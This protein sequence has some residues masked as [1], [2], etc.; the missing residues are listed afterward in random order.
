MSF[1]RFVLDDGWF[2]GR[3]DDRAGLGD[4]TVDADVWPDGLHPLVDAV[5]VHGMQ[6]GLWIEPETV[7]LAREHPDWLLREPG[8]LSWR[9]EFALDRG[10]PSAFAH[11]FEAVSRLVTEYALGYV[12]WEQTRDLLEAVQAGRA[13]WCTAATSLT[14]T[15]PT[16][17]CA[18]AP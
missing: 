11:L 3:R 1:G 12:K 6:F 14:P 4:W 17:A 18:S 16:T 10:N 7:N 5:R 13:A 9:H 15:P 8:T 2:R